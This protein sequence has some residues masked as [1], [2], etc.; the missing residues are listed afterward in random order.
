MERILEKAYL[1]ETIF[2]L[3]ETV[4]S[5][6]NNHIVNKLIDYLIEIRD[7]EN[8][9]NFSEI[10]NLIDDL[11]FEITHYTKTLKEGMEYEFESAQF[12]IDNLIKTKDIIRKNSYISLNNNNINNINYDSIELINENFNKF[13]LDVIYI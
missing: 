10:I 6:Q 11:I 7:N 8:N 9:F 13:N 5:K 2:Q 1:I 12:H 3:N 4:L